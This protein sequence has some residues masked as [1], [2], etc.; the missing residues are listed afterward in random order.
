VILPSFLRGTMNRSS[1]TRRWTRE[2]WLAL[3]ADA[4]VAISHEVA[5]L[6][7]HSLVEP[8]Q[9]R[10]A[11]RIA[12][13]DCGG[14]GLHRRL[15]PWPVG[16]RG[17][18]IVHRRPQRL[19]Q[20]AALPCIKSAGFDV[21]QRIVI[22]VVG[23]AIEDSREL[24]RAVA[25][26]RHHRVQQR[27]DRQPFARDRGGRRIDQERHVGIGDGDPQH[28]AR[29]AH[30]FNLDPR[31]VA[32]FH[33]GFEQEARG[34]LELLP[35]EIGLAG[36]LRGLHALGQR[37]SQFRGDFCRARGVFGC[38]HAMGRPRALGLAAHSSS[39]APG[40]TLSA[41]RVRSVAQAP[42]AQPSPARASVRAAPDRR[43]DRRTRSRRRRCAR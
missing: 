42:Q 10:G 5:K 15:R 6:G 12:F 30:R 29:R 41:R 35:V 24:A 37:C 3:L 1:G 17:V 28:A 2:R 32:A 8:A 39:A 23:I 18:D 20:F 36:E 40:R 38:C 21:D 11:L 26:D 34:I 27:V 14:I 13:L 9:Q 43:S 4:S 25:L 33:R 19:D 31:S 16:D 22:R 7:Q